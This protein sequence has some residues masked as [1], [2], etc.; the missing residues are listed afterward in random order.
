[1][2]T[3]VTAPAAPA[4]RYKWTE[5][6]K[7][8]LI[9]E[10]DAAGRGQRAD[11]LAKWSAKTGAQPQ[12]VQATYYAAKSAF[13]QPAGRPRSATRTRAAR[14]AATTRKVAKSDP[15]AQITA[16]LN[17]KAEIENTLKSEKALRREL[18]QIDRKLAVFG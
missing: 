13:G 3:T 4:T 1:M 11:I 9:A 6:E 10:L 8:A 16:M 12:S 18:K 2:T 14:P 7:R 15:L 17:R 5:V